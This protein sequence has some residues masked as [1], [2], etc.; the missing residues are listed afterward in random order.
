MLQTKNLAEIACV[1]HAAVVGA[2]WFAYFKLDAPTIPANV[3]LLIAL[4]WYLWLSLVAL[5]SGEE[6]VRWIWLLSICLLLLAPTIRTQL[7]CASVFKEG[8]AP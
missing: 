4:L 6:R 7:F 3:W 5:T 2:V 1:L 8:F